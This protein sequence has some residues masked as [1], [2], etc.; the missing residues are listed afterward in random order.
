M[1][2]FDGYC[3]ASCSTAIAGGRVKVNSMQISLFSVSFGLSDP[4]LVK[5]QKMGIRSKDATSSG[6]GSYPSLELFFKV[7]DQGAP[8]QILWLS[9]GFWAAVKIPT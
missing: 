8:S 5:Q 1:V 3:Y 2:S 9:L 4:F 6:P 7:K